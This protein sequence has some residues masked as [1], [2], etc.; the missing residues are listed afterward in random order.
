[1]TEPLRVLA[2]YAHPDD[3]DHEAGGTVAAW[4]ASG[5]HVEYLI[6]T[7]GELGGFHDGPPRHEIPAIR[8]AEQEAAARI[9]GARRVEFL[10]GYR[11]NNVQVTAELRRDITRVIRRFRPG[12]ILT[13][14]PVRSW[15]LRDTDHPDHAA[16]GEAT[17][18][19]VFPDAGS[20]FIYP[21]LHAEGLSSWNVSEVW[22]SGSPTPNEVIDISGTFDRKVDAVRAHDSQPPP[23]DQLIAQFRAEHLAAAAVS[24]LPAGRLAELFHVIRRAPPGHP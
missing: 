18:C 24:G 20:P 1:V 16:V 2:V 21:E 15:I 13:S 7:H 19:A 23:A 8:V 11:D 14:S 4:T 5:A 17:S 6:V 22:Y 9:L 10:A 3:V 12:R